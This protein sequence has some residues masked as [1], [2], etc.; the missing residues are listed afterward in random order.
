M[1][2]ISLFRYSFLI[3][4]HAPNC[5]AQQSTPDRRLEILERRVDQLFR[6][7][8]IQSEPV[9]IGAGNIN[10]RFG[11]PACAGKLLV[12]QYYVVCHENTWKIPEWVTYHLSA[13][14]LKGTR[15]PKRTVHHRGCALDGC[16]PGW[17]C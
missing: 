6:H 13:D 4:L 3:F 10:L 12:K 15:G 16:P 9:V 1:K 8:G 11:Q 7:L 14:D 5:I 17:R 2:R